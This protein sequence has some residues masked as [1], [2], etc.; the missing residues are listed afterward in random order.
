MASLRALECLV[1]VADSGSITQAAL[2]LHSSQPAV[3]HQLA[4]LER[5]TRTPL[6]RR[7][8]RGVKLTPAG[9]AAV[10]D[11]RRAIEAAA[12]AVRSARAVGQVAGGVLRLACAQSLTVPL[13]AAVIRQWHRRYPEVAITLRESTAMDEALGLVESDE[14]DVAVLTTPSAGRFTVTAVA[15]EEIVLA[16]PAGH[17]LAERSAVRL[18]DLDGVPLVHF[19]PDNGLGAWL[20]QSFARAGVQP[21]TVMRTSVTAA[22]PQLA[23]AGLGIAVC[24]VSAVSHGFTGAVRSFSPRWVRE[25][26]AVTSA[27]PDPLVARFIGDLRGHGVRVP[28]GVRTQLAPDATRTGRASDR[29]AMTGP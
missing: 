23:A 24:P 17:P 25:L 14:V 6:L 7:E 20:D 27:E 15:E 16:A 5:E 26:A 2:L 29:D 21:E 12:S 28:R 22:A 18:A 1:A 9:R 13:L 11:A 19:A 8:P 3:S 10:A 4:S